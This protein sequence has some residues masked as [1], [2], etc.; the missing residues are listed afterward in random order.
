MTRRNPASLVRSGIPLISPYYGDAHDQIEQLEE[1]A[2]E[3]IADAEEAI[4]YA[5]EQIS[6]GVDV[7]SNIQ[8]HRKMLYMVGA[9]IIIIAGLTNKERPLLGKLAAAFG[10]IVG[11][12]NYKAHALDEGAMAAA[13]EGLGY[14]GGHFSKPSYIWAKRRCCPVKAHGGKHACPPGYRL[15]IRKGRK[16]CCR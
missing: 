8:T 3:A 5:E 1:A 16:V 6:E 14:A 15:R 10:L 9:P 11:L 12:R 7:V 13:S 2:D 4:V